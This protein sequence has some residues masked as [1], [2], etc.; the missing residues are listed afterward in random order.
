MTMDLRDKW[1]KLERLES[2]RDLYHDVR[3]IL[4]REHEQCDQTRNAI[5]ELYALG[6]AGLVPDPAT[7]PLLFD[8]VGD[9]AIAHPLDPDISFAFDRIRR[10]HYGEW[11]IPHVK[12]FGC[13]DLVGPARYPSLAMV[14]CKCECGCQFRAAMLYLHHRPTICQSIVPATMDHIASHRPRVGVCKQDRPLKPLKIQNASIEDEEEVLQSVA[15]ATCILRRA[16]VIVLGPLVVG[17]IVNGAY[18]ITVDP[19]AVPT[20]Q[21]LA[22][23]AAS[24]PEV[25][26][27]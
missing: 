18:Q 10:L 7:I 14:G 21:M 9:H 6:H 24:L 15:R 22:E 16:G 8:R 2:V 19:E 13:P 17:K 20:E 5:K 4:D 11:T 27:P 3:A 1:L 12:W 23:V 26:A 25:P